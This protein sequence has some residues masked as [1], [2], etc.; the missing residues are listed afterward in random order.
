MD[1]LDWGDDGN[2]YIKHSFYFWMDG[3]EFGQVVGAILV[4]FIVSGL[5]F[6]VEGELVA[7]TEVFLFSIVI[8]L[9][10]NNYLNTL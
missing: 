10:N 8:I 6:V 3:K 9:D 1:I 5:A 2:I 4:L 7:L